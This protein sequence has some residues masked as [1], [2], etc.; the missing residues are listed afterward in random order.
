MN[1]IGSSLIFENQKR[2]AQ[3][4]WRNFQDRARNGVILICGSV[5]LLTLVNYCKKIIITIWTTALRSW[6]VYALGKSLQLFWQKETLGTVGNIAPKLCSYLWM[7]DQSSKSNS[8]RLFN[9]STGFKDF[10]CK[11]NITSKCIKLTTLELMQMTN[12]SS[13]TSGT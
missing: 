7:T 5:L 6:M 1:E 4:M 3:T 9:I 10:Y 12:T 2:S 11:N 8:L 13:D